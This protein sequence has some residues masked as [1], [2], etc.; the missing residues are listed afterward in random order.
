MGAEKVGGCAAT[1][2]E[3]LEFDEGSTGRMEE[4]VDEKEDNE[5]EEVDRCTPPGWARWR[6]SC[7][8]KGMAFGKRQK[9]SKKKG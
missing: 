6:A 7:L 3:W 8:R 5:A 4:L 2:S 9:W 1:I